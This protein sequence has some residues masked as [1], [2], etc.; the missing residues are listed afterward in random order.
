MI[1]AEE[2][3]IQDAIDQLVD[4]LMKRYNTKLIT[5][6]NTIQLYR[7]DRLEYLKKLHKKSQNDGYKLGLKLVR[8]AYIEKERKRAKQKKYKSPIHN[9]KQACDIDFNQAGKYCIDNL[10][11]ISVCFGTHNEES[12]AMIMDLMKSK[13]INNWDSR[14]FLAQL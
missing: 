6:Y 3:W 14:I 13:K 1:D 5:V 12:T 7:W 4:D 11:D 9:T 2:S 10:K 8:G